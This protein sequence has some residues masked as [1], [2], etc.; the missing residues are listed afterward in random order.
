METRFKKEL[1]N[2]SKKEY[3]RFNGFAT[4]CMMK[5]DPML[6]M[7]MAVRTAYGGGGLRYYGCRKGVCK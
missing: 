7:L 1:F 2:G 3:H 5:P 4:K 6:S